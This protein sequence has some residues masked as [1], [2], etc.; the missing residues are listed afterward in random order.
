MMRLIATVLR[1]S[2][3]AALVG[4]P[5]APVLAQSAIKVIVN[6]QAITSYEIAQ[7]A[8]L[9]QLTTKAPNATS[10]ATQELIDD[11]LK[12]QEAKR[13]RVTVAEADVDG[14]FA[15]IAERVKL[16][17]DK[18]AAALKQSGVG[19]DTLKKRLRAQI[20]WSKLVRQRFNR[21]TSVSEQDVIAALQEKSDGTE[22]RKTLQFDLTQ[23][24]IVV[25]SKATPAEVARRQQEAEALRG[26][27]TS[28]AEGL[29]FARSL[30]AVVVKPLGRRLQSDV[31]PVLTKILD[32]T[33]VGRLTPAE[34]DDS[35]FQLIA[36]CDKKV[37]DSDA[38]ARRE[39]EDELMSAEGDIVAR[40]YLRDVRSNAVIEYR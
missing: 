32:E 36:V 40:R 20:A 7:R 9:L 38:A 14:A 27:F 28:C 29:E 11:T 21:Q 5:A 25:P 33:P 23:V 18:L 24:T 22:V 37:L 3:V 19:A 26:R 17:P 35:G 4:A 13:M 2:V 15:Q 8:K 6:D 31:G 39:V 16:S 34:R 1:W 30:P 12:L 10:L